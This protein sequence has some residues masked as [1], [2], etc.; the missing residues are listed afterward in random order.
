MSDAKVMIIG[1]DGGTWDILCPMMERGLMPNLVRLTSEGV[2]GTLRTTVPPITGSA[3][4]SFQTGKNPGKHGIFSFED[5]V[6]GSY[7]RRIINSHTI[8]G[9]PIWSILSRHDRRVCVINVPVTYPPRAVNGYLISGLLSPYGDRRITYPPGLYEEMLS[10]IGD[11]RTYVSTPITPL[12]GARQFADDLIY[13]TRKR[14]E[15]ALWLLERKGE[16]DFFMVHFQC[17]DPLQHRVLD[18]IDPRHPNYAS[19]SPEDIA[20]VCE[21]YR[22]LDEMVGRVAERADERTTLI[23]L[24]DHGFGPALKQVNVNQVLQ[25]QGLLKLHLNSGLSQRVARLAFALARK[26]DVFQVREWLAEERRNTPLH[27]LIRERLRD[28]N[29]GALIDWSATK[30]FAWSAAGT[31]VGLYVN[32]QGREAQGVVQ[33]DEAYEK[34]RD[35]VSQQLIALIDPETGQKVV[36]RVYK[37]EELYHGPHV[38]RMPDLIAQPVGGYQLSPWLN[39]DLVFEPITRIIGDHRMDGIVFFKGARI[40]K[41]DVRVND[42]NIM[43]IAPTVLHLLGVPLPSDMDGQVLTSLLDDAWLRAHPVEIEQVTEGGGEKGTGQGPVFSDAE[44]DIIR[45]R[46]AGLGYFE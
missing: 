5:L 26:L 29:K 25:R 1:L 36:D 9:E 39:G 35:L 10:A 2:S 7:E 24:S 6:Q 16:F 20:C 42:A 21:Y 37:R 41:R 4:P 44:E 18:Y 19:K 27:R 8:D 15:A 33:T 34:L 46:L 13:A 12:H 43:D 40:E 45:E 31:F 30:V 17:L 28:V 3:W 38:E 14:A 11:Y 22:V 32:R 23:G